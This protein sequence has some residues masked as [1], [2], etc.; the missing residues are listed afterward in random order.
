MNGGWRVGI[1]FYLLHHSGAESHQ[2]QATPAQTGFSRPIWPKPA[3]LSPAPS[4]EWRASGR[5]A[6]TPGA[7]VQGQEGQH[8]SQ[9]FFFFFNLLH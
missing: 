4:R 3:A 9:V 7:R 8:H 6:V 5:A 1:G 2:P